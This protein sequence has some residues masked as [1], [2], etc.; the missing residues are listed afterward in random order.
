[1]PLLVRRSR[2]CHAAAQILAAQRPVL[3]Y[4]GNPP[5]EPPKE[6]ASDR[7]C[8]PRWWCDDISDEHV[9]FWLFCGLP[10]RLLCEGWLCW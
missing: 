9:K 1:M 3:D 4:Q 10:L 2:N 5:P 8:A 7:Y 6:Y